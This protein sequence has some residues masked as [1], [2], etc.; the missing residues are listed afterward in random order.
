MSTHE[1][2]TKTNPSESTQDAERSVPLARTS[3]ASSASEVSS[4]S[5]PYPDI[6]SPILFSMRGQWQR[7]SLSEPL[8]AVGNIPAIEMS[9][10]L[11]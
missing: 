10:F 6:C 9:Y 5:P 1:S 7:H 3:N 4:S 2:N 11:E 8:L